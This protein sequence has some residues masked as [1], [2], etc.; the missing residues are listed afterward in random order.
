[1]DEPDTTYQSS[2]A[3]TEV[4]SQT[5]EGGTQDT[6]KKCLIC[7]LPNPNSQ[8][9]QQLFSIDEIAIILV[10]N[11]VWLHCSGCKNFFHL[12]CL[13][14]YLDVQDLIDIIESQFLC[15]N[16]EFN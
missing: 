5:A 8:E 4:F 2:Q 13:P 6:E 15:Q 16:C 9:L 10:K 14:R 11:I 1:M 3:E 7:N 12:K